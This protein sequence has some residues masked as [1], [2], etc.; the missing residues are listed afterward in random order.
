MGL[1]LEA[2]GFV[3]GCCW[4]PALGLEFW[5]T[6]LLRTISPKFGYRSFPLVISSIWFQ[7]ELNYPVLGATASGYWPL[8][9]ISYSTIFSPFSVKYKL[10]YPVFK[11]LLASPFVGWLRCSP[12]APRSILGMTIDQPVQFG[13]GWW[14]KLFPGSVEYSNPQKTSK[15]EKPGNLK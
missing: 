1:R 14:F 7:N 4:L 3:L 8:V 13:M 2:S 11:A 6:N 10:S 15:R 9:V 5:V 12:L